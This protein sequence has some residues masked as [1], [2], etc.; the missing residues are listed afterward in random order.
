MYCYRHDAQEAIA[1]CRHCGKAA[2]PD[3]CEDTGQGIACSA[4]CAAELQDT[5][6]LTVRLKQSF[7]IGLSPPMPA[8]VSMYAMFGAILLAVGV[9]LTFSRH[10]FDYLSFAMAAVFFVMSWLSYKRFRDVCLTC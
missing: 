5:Y 1:V 6:R 10:D 9:Y 2:C 3:C 4:N 8:S 7:G